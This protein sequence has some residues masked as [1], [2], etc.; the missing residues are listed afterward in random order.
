MNLD[1]ASLGPSRL[2][3]FWQ[4]YDR[5]EIGLD[6]VKAEEAALADDFKRRW[7][8]ALLLPGQS[9]LSHSLLTEIGR[10]RGIADLG[11]VRAACEGALDELKANWERVVKQGGTAEVTRYYDSADRMIEELMWWHRVEDDTSPL[12]YVV[13]RDLAELTGGRRY[14]DFGSGVGSAGVLFAAAGFA[15]TLADVSSVLGD[16]CRWR[17]GQRGIAV[18]IVDLKSRTL[19]AS[20]FDF[21]TAMDV[22]EH[23]ADPVGTLDG[24]AA[25]MAPG[26]YLFGRFAADEDDADRPQH[27][28]HDFGPVFARLDALGFTEI[29]QD[30]CLWGHKAFRKPAA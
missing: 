29:W 19:P 21:V 25:A 8:S 18:D 15:V 7:T 24:L 10:Y 12:S 3:A 30:R 28:V 11:L 9:D 23:L 14:L 27:I 16:F 4:R 22:F 5:G 1:L 17:L 13:A 6:R 26:A 20:S 2:L